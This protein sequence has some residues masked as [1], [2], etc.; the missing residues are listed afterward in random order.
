MGVPVLFDTHAHLDDEQL[1]LQLP[2]VLAR[3]RDAGVESVVA[4]GTTLASSRAAVEIAGRYPGVYAAVG[5]QP[6]HVAEAAAGDWEQIVELAKAPRVAAIGET[7]LD[8]Y[9]DYA[10]FE[11]QQEYFDR[12]IRLSQSSGLPLVI[13][14]RDC[15]AEMV[16][17]LAA[18]G[19][20]G[21]LSGVMHSFTGDAALAKEC[22]EL[23]LYISFAGMVTYRKSNE[24]REVAKTIPSD[25]ILVE[26]D[27]PYLSPE[28]RRGQR[29]NEPALVVH[30]AEC[31][32]Q[33]RGLPLE[34]F[35]A[36]TTANARRLLRL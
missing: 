35:A 27:S 14:M 3:A 4:V 31:L 36:Q 5:I 20:R 28:P 2:D 1:L 12:H 25:R 19:S 26:T 6:N 22:L 13:H 7:G 15:G 18:A 29:P 9:W 10:P 33:L 24:L 32:A 11:L 16:S 17:M 8:R 30:T 21:P 34:D 23:G